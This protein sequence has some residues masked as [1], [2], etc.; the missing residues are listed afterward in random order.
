[1]LTTAGILPIKRLKG[2]FPDKISSY[3][4]IS[5]S[6]M[7]RIKNQDSKPINTIRW[8]ASL[9]VLAVLLWLLYI[10]AGRALCHIAI[11]QIAELTNTKIKI[12]SVDFHTDGSV[13]IEDIIISPRRSQNQDATI[14]TAEEV[15]VRFNPGSLFLLRPRLQVIDVNDF[16]FNAQYD[17][18]TG[19]SNLSELEIRPPEDSFSKMPRISLNGGKLQYSKIS[20]DRKDIAAS[21]PIYARF[22]PDEESQQG[23]VFEITTAT[24]ASGF[25]KSRLT[26]SWKPGLVTIAGGI[27]S[28]DVPELE[29]AWIIDIMAAELEYD[30]NDE[31]TLK[32]RLK[33]LQSKRSESLDKLAAVGPPALRKSN[34][35]TAL[36]RFFDRYQPRGSVDV[37]LS[38]TGN[39]KRMKENKLTGQVDCKDVAFTYSGFQYP[40]ENLTG[41]LNFTNDSVTFDN[42]K[43][44]HGDVGLLFNGWTRGFG[45][46]RRYHIRIIS[47]NIP[48]DKDLYEALSSKQK[49]FWNCFSPVGNGAVD[50]RLDRYS[51]AEKQMNLTLEL[52][53]AEAEYC[54][55]PYPLK[56][57]TGKIFFTR[58]KIIFSDIVSRENERTITLNGDITTGGAD[59][60]LYDISV[61]VENIPLDSAL[62]ESL[63]AGQRSFFRKYRPSGIADGWIKIIARGDMPGDFVADL[64][65]TD[66]SINS[67]ELLLPVT[68]VSARAVFTPGSIDVKEFSGRY[69]ESPMSL[70]GHFQTDPEQQTLYLM[71]LH[72][73]R[74][75]FNEDFLKLLPESMNEAVSGLKPDG[76]I[77]LVA[78]LDK[79]SYTE[80]P[81]YI[82]TV[83]CLGNSIQLPDFP[84]PLKNITGTLIIK[85]DRVGL[86]NVMVSIGD[87]DSRLEDITAVKLNGDLIL[88]DNKLTDGFL[89]LA[90]DE[91][92]FN[93]RLEKIL[94]QQAVSLYDKLKLS[95]NFG[96][97]MNDIKVHFG[98]DR[99][100]S[101]DFAGAIIL[102][103]CV[104]NISGTGTQLNL[105]LNTRG[106]YQIQGGLLGCRA[107]IDNGE[108][109]VRGKTLTD[110]EANIY[111][112]P[113][114]GNWTIEDFVA[115]CYG[116]K[117]TG[118]IEFTHINDASTEHVLQIAFDNVDLKQYLSDAGVEAAGDNT[119]TSGKMSG[120]LS[121]NTRTDENTYRIGSLRLKINDMRVGKMSPLAKLLQ[122]LNLTEPSDYAFDQMFVDSYIKGDNMFVKKLDL[123]GRGIAFYGSG[124]MDLVSRN[125]NLILTARGRRLATDDPSILQSLT[126]GLGQAVV[127]MEVTGN[128]DDPDVKTKAL[129]V[130]EGTLQILVTRPNASD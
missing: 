119:Y 100:K 36:Q 61:N 40:I 79:K 73:E 117:T 62:E 80:P 127:R 107:T 16:V 1:M 114:R 24:M 91:I 75:Q 26:G 81:D 25:G 21:V 52:L 49:E 55:F 54:K 17:L 106:A 112:D 38:V 115:D 120:S 124:W 63:P 31:F 89:Q 22:G 15:F 37:D 66:A 123:S 109:V 5:V 87:V 77:D 64:S 126:E 70:T 14:L 42:L 7:T 9:L 86:Q 35:F 72:L 108:M 78:E 99:Q 23:Y 93:D 39:L 65:F 103:K 98:E 32:L 59:G 27:S 57:L 74:V 44:S 110:L 45:P 97:D 113:N 51:Q 90:A 130:I 116:G 76:Q 94:P 43:G 47:D 20:G 67:D 11:G 10:Y 19:W 18:D 8:F 128:F 2:L 83:N 50:F 12:G 33:D 60:S 68:D 121:I 53:G 30:Q 122:V 46:D 13:S 96:L 41:T 111:Y 56:N 58:D 125:I 69:G 92:A 4:L 29:M 118:K 71:S 84:S 48:L 129:P 101:V 104:S 82:L 105:V 88:E 34:I 3:I 95:G 6:S 28:L 85:P 102:K